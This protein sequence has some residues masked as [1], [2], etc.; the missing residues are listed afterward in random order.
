[1]VENPE[2]LAL[3]DKHH[4]KHDITLETRVEVA[5]RMMCLCPTNLDAYVIAF[6]DIPET[7]KQFMSIVD[8][9][10][11]EQDEKLHSLQEALGELS[12]E[13]DKIYSKEVSLDV[14][15]SLDK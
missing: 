8:F 14:A 3:L 1:M 4:L 11:M 7:Y 12:R 9:V 2:F 6:G 15:T 10:K 13:G 5:A